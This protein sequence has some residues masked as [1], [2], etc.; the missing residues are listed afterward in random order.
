MKNV[1]LLFTT[2]LSVTVFSQISFAPQQNYKRG[3]NYTAN[4][5][6]NGTIYYTVDGKEPSLSSPFSENVVNLNITKNTIVKAKF[7]TNATTLS[8]TFTRKFWHTLEEKK[9]Y[10]KPPTSW[11]KAPCSYMNMVDPET[12]IDFYPPGQNMTAVCEGWFKTLYTYGKANISF[13]NC[14]YIGGSPNNNFIEY[15]IIS[16]DIVYYDASSGPINNPPSCILAT[17]ESSKVANVKI[18]ENPVKDF[19]QVKSDIKFDRYI[20]IDFSGKIVIDKNYTKDIEVSQ[21]Q[22]GTYFIKFLGNNTVQH[23]LKFIKN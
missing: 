2:L 8:E 3:Q 14:A 11:T 5:Y 7:K 15:T 10:F 9:V 22:K 18:V 1:L 13:N 23:Y 20:I 6:A 19:L 12:T 4:I 21:L 17:Q 16:E